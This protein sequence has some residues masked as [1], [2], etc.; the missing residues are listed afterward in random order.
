[1]LAQTV[2]SDPASIF[3]LALPRVPPNGS[4]R[5]FWSGWP[6]IFDVHRWAYENGLV[7]RLVGL[8][9]TFPGFALQVD[10]LEVENGETLALLGPSGSG[11]S[12]LLRL[13]AGLEEPGPA[14]QILVDGT[15]LIP[16]PPEQRAVG[17]VF[18]DYALFPHL[19][20]RQNIAFGLREARWEANRLE[21]RVG[22]LLELTRLTPQAH[23]RPDQL[24]GGERQRVALARALANLP[25]VL[26]LDEPL[27]ALDRELREELLLELRGILRQSG[28]LTL[29]VTHDQA[30]AFVLANR[31]AVMRTGKIVQIDRPEALY[32]HPLDLWTAAFLGHKNLLSAAQSQGLRLPA[33][34]HLLPPGAVKLGQGPAAEVKERLFLGPRVA[35][36]LCWQGLSLYWEGQSTARQGERVGLEVDLTQAIPLENPR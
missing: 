4:Y 10:S 2:L 26:L 15:N 7:L 9:K 6:T 1:M 20:V 27:G 5:Y 18:Q 24:S 13:I 8:V 23:K 36:T 12:T 17:M 34:P 25:K 32:E 33:K 35:L 16:F 3:W 19:S 21:A 14:S 31:V 30:E 22:E 29:V 28:L 11:K